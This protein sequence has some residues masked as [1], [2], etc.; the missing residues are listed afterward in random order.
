M[1]IDTDA[2]ESTDGGDVKKF[3]SS[4]LITRS[5]AERLE[6]TGYVDSGTSAT[7][8]AI[9]YALSKREISSLPQKLSDRTG[10][11]L[12]IT[13]FDPNGSVRTLIKQTCFPDVD[14]THRQIYDLAELLCEAGME[15][16]QKELDS[17]RT[18]VQIVSDVS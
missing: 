18:L 6:K 11:N 3:F 5:V 8:I 17:G 10:F 7:K 14:A 1:T 12:G 4:S 16:I 2:Q 9:A 15:D 13:Q